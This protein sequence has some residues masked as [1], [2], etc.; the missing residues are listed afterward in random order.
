MPKRAKPRVQP[1]I[2]FTPSIIREMQ[3]EDHDLGEI[4]KLKIEKSERQN[5]DRFTSR[6]PCFK[7]WIQK[8]ELLDIKNEMLCYY[9][10]DNINQNRWK[11]CAP[12]ALQQ[13]VLWHLHDSPTGGHQ[14]ISRTQKRAKLC[15]FYW[16]NMNLNVKDYVHTYD[17]CEER[18]QPPRRN[19]QKMKSYV[20]G[21]RF[22]RLASDIAGPFP[23]TDRGNQ[24]ILIIE[25]YFT[26]FTEVYPLTDMNAENVVN[27]F[28][29]GW[30]KRYE[31]HSDQGT[32]YESQLFQGICKLLSISKT[33]RTALDL[34]GW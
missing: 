11:I 20:M 12:K 3:V 8:W 2:N 15:P 6:N 28:L 9:W 29:R 4:L 30:I 7:L 10:E 27:V 14:G 18:K 31:M 26:K 21:A 16:P 5:F 34:M 23:V 25:D 19:R 24:Y 17:I 33:R 1:E 32:Q 13:Y 22:E